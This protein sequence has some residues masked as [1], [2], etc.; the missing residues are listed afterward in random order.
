MFVAVFPTEFPVR[1]SPPASLMLLAHSMLP[2]M[3]A[4][5]LPVLA[6]LAKYPARAPLLGGSI[7]HFAPAQVMATLRPPLA[8]ALL[9]VAAV[10]VSCHQLTI[11][12]H[13]NSFNTKMVGVG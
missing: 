7:P 5:A 13:K 9:V 6:V 8:P 4:P 2:V 1:T 12:S 10:T 3:L 11:Q